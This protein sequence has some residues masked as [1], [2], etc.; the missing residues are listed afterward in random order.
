MMGSV[1]II[2][3]SGTRH[4]HLIAEAIASGVYCHADTRVDLLR[5][6]KQHPGL[7][8]TELAALTNL[9]TQ[10]LK[11]KVRKLKSFG[12]TVSIARGGYRLS[13]EVARYS[14]A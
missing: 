3:F 7:R 1:A 9:D 10:V 6:I 14:I 4:T 2:Y 5:L 12:L 11:V 8:A 13:H